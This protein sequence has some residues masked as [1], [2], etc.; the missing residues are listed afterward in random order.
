M[1]QET[2]TMSRKE[3]QRMV[4][5]EQVSLGQTTL[6]QAAEHMQISRRQAIRLKARYLD[7]GASGLIHRSRG[8]P[9]SRRKPDDLRKRA[10]ALYVDQYGDFGP[11]LAAEK[12]E[13][14]DGL[15][16]NHETLRRWLIAEGHWQVRGGGRTHRRRRQRRDRF[17]QLVQ[18]DGSDHDWFEERGP[19]ACL[20]VMIDDATGRMKLHLAPTETAHAALTVVRKWA[21]AYGLPEALYADRKTVYF[22]THVLDEPARRNQREAHSGWG[23]VV[24]D[25]GISL[26]PAYSPQ[27]KGRVERA[28]ATLQ[29]RLVK[30][31]RLRGIDT[32]EAANAMLDE[33]ADALGRRFALEPAHPADAHRIFAPNDQRAVDLAFSIDETRTVMRDY[34]FSLDGELW[35]IVRQKPLPMPGSKVTVWKS[36]DGEIRCFTG[37]E[38]LEIERSRPD[39]GKVKARLGLHQEPVTEASR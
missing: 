15:C 22:A 7:H 36:L 32:I 19:R 8:K 3:R 5:L 12:M 23:R 1:P 39:A 31:L 14:R 6:A 26:I 27:A 11:T 20:M 38:E 29:D 17:G 33:F 18:I 24:W 25:L 16:V 2:L 35:Q 21:L 28:N 13:E 9:S 4:I 10:L 30:E 34:T 37:K